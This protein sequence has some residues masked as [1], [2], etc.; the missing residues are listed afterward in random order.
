MH[1]HYCRGSLGNR[2][3]KTDKSSTSPTR[4]NNKR[5]KD[6]LSNLKQKALISWSRADVETWLDSLKEA[7]LGGVDCR[8]LC[9]YDGASPLRNGAYMAEVKLENLVEYD[10]QGTPTQT[11]RVLMN[12]I[13]ELRRTCKTTQVAS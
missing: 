10:N 2:R 3:R 12:Q 7:E 9:A 8:H 13:R 4:E 6:N 5:R 1:L 11:L